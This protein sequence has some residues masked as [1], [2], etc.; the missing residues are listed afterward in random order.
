MAVYNF[1]ENPSIAIN[2]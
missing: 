1:I 2:R